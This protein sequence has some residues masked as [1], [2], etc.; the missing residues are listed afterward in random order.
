MSRRRAFVLPVVLIVVGLLALTLAGFVFFVRAEMAGAQAK[1]DEQQARLAAQSGLQEVITVLRRSPTDSTA[2]WDMPVEVA[3]AEIPSR[4]R[5]ALVWS[6]AYTR[7]N[8]PLREGRE[9]R[10]LRES[11]EIEQAWRY[12][13][14]AQNHDGEEYTMRY[15]ITPEAGKININLAEEEDLTRLLESVLLDLG[16]ENHPE[17]TDAL[18]DWLDEDDEPRANGAER[19]YYEFLEPGYFPKNGPLDTLEELLMVKGFTAAVLYGEDVNRNGILDPNEDDGETTEPYYDNADGILDRGIAPYLTVWAYDLSASGG[20]D[21]SG[22]QNGGGQGDG[23]QD[24]G[25]QGGEDLPGDDSKYDTR[26]DITEL[27]GYGDEGGEDQS[28]DEQGDGTGQQAEAPDM[29]IDI[30]SAPMRVLQAIGMSE[31][32]AENVVTMRREQEA[33]A[34][35]SLDWLVTSGALEPAEYEQVKDRLTTKSFQFHV[36]ILGY[37]DHARIAKRYEWIVEVRG[38]VVQVLYH[39]DLTRLGLGWPIDEETALVEQQ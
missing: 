28:G 29:K 22:D 3:D 32:G 16:V 37:A 10:D 33:E 9:R 7:E 31:E 12:S 11:G 20:G 14:V 2:W 17:L 5:H 18:L 35:Q 39:R 19:D 34:L 23:G 27:D 38:S 24:S 15:G 25:D 4:F 26:Q 21:Q 1:R 13:V 8:D 36:E 6:N 30:N